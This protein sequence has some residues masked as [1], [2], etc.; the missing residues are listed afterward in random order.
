M[1]FQDEIYKIKKSKPLYKRLEE[2]FEKKYE[3]ETLAEKK[4][5]LEELRNLK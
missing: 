2:K 4:K 5:R 1:E 3:M